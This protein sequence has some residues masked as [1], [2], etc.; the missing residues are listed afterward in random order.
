MFFFTDYFLRW[1]QWFWHDIRKPLLVKFQ[2]NLFWF[3]MVVRYGY[4]NNL[5]EMRREINIVVGNVCFP[6]YTLIYNI[7]F[8]KIMFFTEQK[9][10]FYKT[11]RFP[12]RKNVKSVIFF[13]E[14]SCFCM[15]ELVIS[16]GHYEIVFPVQIDRIIGFFLCTW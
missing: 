6:Y 9:H 8:T 13:A 7:L 4:T 16:C 15:S 1:M 11:I 2:Y 10:Y 3:R 14:H 12:N 5:I